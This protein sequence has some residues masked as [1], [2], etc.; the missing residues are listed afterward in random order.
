MR[1]AGFKVGNLA[2]APWLAVVNVG[3]LHCR[4]PFLSYVTR[5]I[6]ENVGDSSM[7]PQDCRTRKAC[8]RG[9]NHTRPPA[10][11]CRATVDQVLLADPAGVVANSARHEL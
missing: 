9:R 6:G 5:A 8:R 10:G 2:L 7:P 4:G 3:A 1:Y 11:L